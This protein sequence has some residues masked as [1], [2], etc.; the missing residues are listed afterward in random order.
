MKRIIT[1]AIV[2][3]S[4]ILTTSQ[5]ASAWH[6]CQFGIGFNISSEGANNSVMWGVVKGGPAPHGY[7]YGYG[8]GDI[9]KPGP[10]GYGFG[11]GFGGYGG[12]NDG[13]HD[14]GYVGDPSMMG[15]PNGFMGGPNGFAMP[16]QS[17]PLPI[18]PTALPRQMPHAD[19]QPVG[20]WN[21]PTY[22]PMAMYMPYYYQPM[23]YGF[24][25]GY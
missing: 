1:L 7:G 4:L 24:G 17:M 5:K 3:S 12:G 19:A 11:G 2:A 15:G 20:Y 23:W 14:G 6:K 21:Y 13:G 9:G 8:P 18:G 16:S 25:Y 22:D 10:Y